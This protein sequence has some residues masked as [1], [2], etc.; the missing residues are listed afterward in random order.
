MLLSILKPLLA[1]S[2]LWTS[3]FSASSPSEGCGNNGK[4]SLVPGGPSKYFNLLSNAGGDTVPWK[5][6]LRIHLPEHYQ[7]DKPAP[8]ILAFH[9]KHRNGTSFETMTKLSKGD[10][11]IDAIVVYP[12]GI[13]VGKMRSDDRPNNTDRI[14]S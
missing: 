3:A 12:D 8:L 9:P 11:N 14:Y 6:R 7:P 4:S 10:Y 13:D 2:F 1:T 5:R